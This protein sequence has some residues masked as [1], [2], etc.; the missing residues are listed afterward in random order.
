MDLQLMFLQDSTSNEEEY[1]KIGLNC[2]DIC[3]ALDRGMGGKRLDELNQSVCGA[4]KQLT[5]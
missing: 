5:T 2:A 4:I 1:V 3:G